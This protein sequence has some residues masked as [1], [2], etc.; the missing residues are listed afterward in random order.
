MKIDFDN[1]IL[2][3]LSAAF[4]YVML[5][6]YWMLCSMPVVTAGAATTAMLSVT[7]GVDRVTGSVSKRFFR[8]FKSNFKLATR[9]W[10]TFLALGIVLAEDVYACWGGRLQGNTVVWLRGV[11]VISAAV[12]FLL[13]SVIFAITAKFK[14]NYRQAFY[15][16][17]V[18]L[19][20][21]PL[22]V[23]AALS[24]A[25]VFAASFVF[26]LA[27]GI[28]PA[29]LALY[30]WTLVFRRMFRPY[31]PQNNPCSEEDGLL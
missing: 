20:H 9:I 28:L 6:F 26:L 3:A 24:L 23:F 15:N 13:L 21:K 4:D 25:A 16:A 8:A 1:R 11:T 31:L 17:F 12:Y 2:S 7:L 27:V 29:G 30:L 18:M 10:L 22:L 14:V 19:L 5:A